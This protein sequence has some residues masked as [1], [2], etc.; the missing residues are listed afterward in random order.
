M[1][2]IVSHPAPKCH[3]PPCSGVGRL[4]TGEV[5]QNGAIGHMIAM[6][7]RDEMFERIPHPL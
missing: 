7:F 4:R 1:R 5:V 3:H 2:D 6:T